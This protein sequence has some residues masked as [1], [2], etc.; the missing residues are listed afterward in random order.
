MRKPFMLLPA[1]LYASCCLFSG[2]ASSCNEP[3]D[4]S[5]IDN[6]EQFVDFV[7]DV[8]TGRD[9]RVL[10][11]TDI[12]TLDFSQKRYETR[13][14]SN[15]VAD[16]YNGYEKYVGQ[17]IEGYKPDFII[18][19]GDNTY[20]EFDDNGEQHLKL[21]QF[22][23]S[24]QIPWAPV[25]GNHDIESNMGADWQSEQFENATYCLFKQR[26]LTGNGNY[27][28]GLRQGGKLK[29][30]FYMLDSNGSGHASKRSLANGHTVTTAGFGD[31]QIEWYT[32]SITALKGEFPN[33]TISMAF[34]I[35]FAM[36]ETALEEYGYFP[37]TIRNNPID[38]DQLP[39]AKEK[40]DF[41]YIGG[42]AHSD[43]DRNLTVWNS[44]KT[45]GIDSVFVGHEHSNSS[46]V[47]YEGVRLT[48]GQKSS[49]FD[50]HNVNEKGA[51]VGGTYINLSKLDGTIS[52]AGLYLYD[53]D[54]GYTP[55]DKPDPQAPS[56]PHEQP[57]DSYNLSSYENVVGALGKETKFAT[58]NDDSYSVRFTLTPHAFDGAVECYGYTS[59]TDAKSGIRVYIKQ[60]SIRLFNATASFDFA[61]DTSYEMEIGFLPLFDGNTTH[62]FVKINGNVILWER[63]E[64]Y[65]KPRGN[66]SI[67]ASKTTDSFTLS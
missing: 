52:D 49:T 45:L 16:T 4:N 61:L 32:Q 67:S 36:F 47:E 56:L 40:G 28:V 5:V 23:D 27:C 65:E 22:M 8:P 53:H 1:L 38:L 2:C 13:V 60:N 18:M 21:I 26:E 11:L 29:R 17:V 41:G 24:F 34:H 63:I 43:W 3:Q 9:I 50:S 42:S 51:V 39:S 30:V 54:N 44:I 58:I 15:E 7:V 37:S 14:E 31:D 33:V 46:S 57:Y 10:Q 66:F 12:Q 59:E 48:F 64:S 19:T 55:N 25:F 35:Q 6:A 20:G 62:V